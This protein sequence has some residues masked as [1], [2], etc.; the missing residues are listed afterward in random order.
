LNVDVFDALADPTRRG[1]LEAVAAEPASATQ[2]AGTL[3]ITR[4]AVVKHLGA[5]AEAGLVQRER[6]GRE[7]RYRVRPEPLTEAMAWMVEVGGR[8]DERLARLQ[9]QLGPGRA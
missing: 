4:Q 7:V 9:R 6:A 5:L 3:P 1:I 2:L 8:W